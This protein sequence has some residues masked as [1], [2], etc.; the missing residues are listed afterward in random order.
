MEP[1]VNYLVHN[2][3]PLDP[4][5]LPIYNI[6]TGDEKYIINHKFVILTRK[7]LLYNRSQWWLSSFRVSATTTQ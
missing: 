7:Q 1:K 3:P 4:I 5:V 2:S 6:K